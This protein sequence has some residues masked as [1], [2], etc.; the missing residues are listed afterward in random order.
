MEGGLQ[1][2]KNFTQK[3]EKKRPKSVI[4]VSVVRL[5]GSN[6]STAERFSFNLYTRLIVHPYTNTATH[7]NVIFK[8]IAQYFTTFS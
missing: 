5:M 7:Y 1:L 4:F 2:C 3:K 6:S 8:T